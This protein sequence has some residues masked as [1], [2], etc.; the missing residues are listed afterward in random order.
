ML[1]HGSSIGGSWLTKEGKMYL[2]VLN[3]WREREDKESEETNEL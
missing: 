1:E 2:T 3:A